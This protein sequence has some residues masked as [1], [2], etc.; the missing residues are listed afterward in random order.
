MKSTIQNICVFDLETTGLIQAKNAIIEIACCPF[1]FQYNDLKEFDSGIMKIYD[2]REIVEQA[3]MSNNITRDQIANGVD[4]KE[5]IDNF[6]NYLSKLKVGNSKPVLAGHTIDHFDIPFLLDYFKF[7]GKD[8]SKYVNEEFTIDTMWWS[9]LRW[10]EAV[11][12]KLGTCCETMGVELVNA[13][14]AM[15]DTR[16]TKDLVKLFLKSFRSEITSGETK[17]KVRSIF[18]F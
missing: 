1:D 16:A 2:N 14:R 10:E 5:T 6:C 11:N 9:R 15:A 17:K 3:L 18:Q 4:P 12:Y 8:L 7:Y 13:H